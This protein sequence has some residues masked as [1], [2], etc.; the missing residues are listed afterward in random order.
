MERVFLD[1]CL[2]SLFPEG[3]AEALLARAFGLSGQ[4]FRHVK[5]R[6]TLRFEHGGKAYFIKLHGG[7]G[8]R[9]IFKCLSQ[10]KRPVLGAANEYDAIRL[11]ERIGVRTMTCRAFA[12]RGGLNP[13][14]R[15][16]FIVTDELAGKVSLE[17]FCRDWKTAP[18]PYPLKRGLIEALAETCAKM[19]F[20]GLNHR[21]CYLCH[22][23]LDRKE[24]ENGKISLYVLDLHR[25]EIRR[26][27]PR[28]MRVKDLA[29]IFFSAM[30]TGLGKR[31]ALRFIAKYESF[32][33]L[34][35]ALWRD[36]LAAA[37][38]LYRKEWK[39]PPELG[40]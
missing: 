7:V 28:R 12:E 36:V 30:D 38:R 2:R 39:R 34:S 18:P 3:S 23:L 27:I 8:W 5:N 26:R 11:L 24:L 6:R 10:G 29:G 25:A 31:D 15:E 13:A 40:K 17:D 21:D 22:F 1:P 37:V 4:E 20:A 14:A 9:E 19:H 33:K 32:G 35:P 16:S